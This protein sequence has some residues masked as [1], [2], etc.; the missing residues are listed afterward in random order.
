MKAAALIAG[1]L[2]ALTGCT[3]LIDTGEEESTRE[4]AQK[5]SSSVRPMLRSAC[6]NCHE[7]ASP[8]GPAFLGE[9]GESDDYLQVM[10]SSILGNFDPMKASL[11][12]KGPHSG[13]TWWTSD[14]QSKITAWLEVEKREINQP[15][16]VDVMAAWAGCMTLE[17]WNESKV[18]EWANKQTDQNSTCGGCHADGEY[19]FFSNPA[20]ETMFEQLRT[21]QGISSLFQISAVTGKPEVV[22]AFGKLRSKCSGSGLHPGAAVDDEYVEYLDRFYEL[23]RAMLEAGVCESPGYPAPTGP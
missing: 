14:Q 21:Q 16:A 18:Y 19:G 17:N 22:P 4:G 10:S 6:A 23:T 2:L 12:T 1:A 8:V 3:G 11:L 13:A 20:R 15:G 5:F 7:G 9:S